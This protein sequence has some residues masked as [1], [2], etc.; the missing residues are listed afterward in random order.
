MLK[1]KPLTA[2]KHFIIARIFKVYKIMVSLPAYPSRKDTLSSEV[3]C[4]EFVILY[5]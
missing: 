1:G 5:L 4:N 2:S 3:M